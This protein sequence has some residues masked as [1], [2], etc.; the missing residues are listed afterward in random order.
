MPTDPPTS[1]QPGRPPLTRAQLRAQRQ[2][3]PLTAA[4]PGPGPAVRA[5]GTTGVPLGAGIGRRR[6]RRAAGW[7]VV[8]V[9]VALVSG[10][11]VW[12]HARL[13]APPPAA[14]VL[15]SVSARVTAPGAL[16]PMPWPKGAEAA[17]AIGPLG[18]TAQSGPER[19]EPVASLTKIMTCYIVLHDHPL[20][21][22]P[23]SGKPAPPGVNGP[24]I[25][26]TPADV[27][28]FDTDSALGQSNAPVRAGEVLTE[29]Q[30]LEGALIHSANNLAEA[31][32][33]WDAGSVPAFVAKMNATAA[34]LGMHD[35]H[36]VDASG[37]EP[38]S[39]STAADILVVAARAMAIPAFAQTVDMRSVSLPYDGTLYSY[40]PWL[41]VDG[42]VGVKSGYTDAA[43]GSDVAAVVRR[44]GGVPVT[45]LA[46]VT[47]FHGP[48]AIDASGLG[49]LHLANAAA[50]AIEQVPVL[51]SGQQV[52]VAS[53]VDGRVAARTGPR[54]AVLAMP[55]QVVQ[56]A[57]TP[58]RHVVAGDPAG[59]P[60]GTVWVTIGWQHHAVPALMQRRLPALTLSQR[61]F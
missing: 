56:V 34:T 47:G 1:V 32:A 6:R 3:R 8:V 61:L 23:P 35:T 51:S 10:V 59:T 20:P 49:A 11:A 7:V 55:Q 24:S 13:S 30:L 12:A 60:V 41:G 29:R 39:V 28:Y 26:I 48:G 33:A 16:P 42:A 36:F 40:T 31:L 53:D 4:G 57:W 19:P 22:L 18:F 52:A 17:V 44:V 54:V 58:R 5:R 2:G 46:A 15:P 9:V 27:G 37:Y 50:G 43:G 38:G 45:V 21:P 25:T 14:R